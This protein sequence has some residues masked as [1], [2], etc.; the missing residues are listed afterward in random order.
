MG[1]S[2][3]IVLKSQLNACSRSQ[4]PLLAVGASA[5]TGQSYQRACSPMR[6]RSSSYGNKTRR[7]SRT[8]GYSIRNDNVP[9][10]PKLSG[11]SGHNSDASC[12]TYASIGA[13]N[14]YALRTAGHSG[15]CETYFIGTPEVS[16][17]GPTGTL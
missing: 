8:R 12:K 5:K 14:E 6:T 4:G 7:N 11:Y 9:A 2:R 10:V 13:G 1:S 17:F 15:S 16:F 3:R